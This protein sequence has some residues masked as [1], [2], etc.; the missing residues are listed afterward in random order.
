MD[1]EH[2][3][4]AGRLHPGAGDPGHHRRHRLCHRVKLETQTLLNILHWER[5]GL[6]F[7]IVIEKVKV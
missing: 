6:K 3:P 5:R 4:G 7:G 2:V 1:R